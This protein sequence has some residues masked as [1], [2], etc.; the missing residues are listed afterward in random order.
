[1]QGIP[2]TGGM[3]SKI[4]FFRAGRRDLRWLISVQLGTAAIWETPRQ[5]FVAAALI[6]RNALLPAR[7]EI[8]AIVAA[9]LPANHLFCLPLKAKLSIR[10]VTKV[11][12]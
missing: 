6:S 10:F 2:V 1:M 9:L 7:R 5:S 4:G 8:L 12:Q 11:M 3:A